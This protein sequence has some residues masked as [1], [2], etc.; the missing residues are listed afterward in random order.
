VIAVITFKTTGEPVKILKGVDP[1]SLI[2]VQFPDGREMHVY[3]EQLAK[4]DEEY[5]EVETTLH[6]M[7]IADHFAD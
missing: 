4:T 5:H 7:F 2:P 3:I 1:H 6:A